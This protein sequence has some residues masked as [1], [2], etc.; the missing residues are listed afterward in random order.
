MDNNEKL[1]DGLLKADGIDPAGVTDSE[2]A[3]FSRM[4][5]AQ[6]K[7][8]QPK[9]GHRPGIWR[10]IMKNRITKLAAAAI[11]I[12]ALVGITLLDKTVTPAYALQQ[13]LEAMKKEIWMHAVQ[14]M[15]RTDD[16]SGESWISL[17]HGIGAN[18]SEDGSA[19]FSISSE[20]KVYKYDPLTETISIT[21]PHKNNLFNRA[22]SFSGYFE[23]IIDELKDNDGAEV[24]T[25][26]EVRNGSNVKVVEVKVPR[27]QPLGSVGTEFWRFT[28][29]EKTFL[30]VRLELEGYNEKAEFIEVADMSFDYPGSGPTDIYQLGVPK[31][32]K[33]ID[34]RPSIEV[35]EI[36]RN[37]KAAR[38][39]KLSRYTALALYTKSKDTGPQVTEE[40]TIYYLDSDK[41]RRETLSPTWDIIESQREGRLDLVPEM[42]DS[43]ESMLNWWTNREHLS[44]RRAYMYDGEHEHRVTHNLNVTEFQ[45]NDEV[46][47][48]WRAKNSRPHDL[49][50]LYTGAGNLL[51]FGPYCPVI[52]L[53][54]ND[55]SKQ[56][57]LICLQG[58]E[59][60]FTGTLQGRKYK[61]LCYIDQNREY[62]CKRIEKYYIQDKL[63]LDEYDN[64]EDFLV[65]NPDP[66]LE[67]TQLTVN[68]I[69]EFG[70]TEDGR[71][72][73]KKIER[74]NT[75]QR[76]N[77][78]LQE[79]ITTWMVYLDTAREFP[80]DIF[81][82]DAFSKFLD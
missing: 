2:R 44:L 61:T 57:D 48:K 52:T 76:E 4:L 38:E 25:T 33:I 73:P 43:L 20:N 31:T 68:E 22:N 59:R 75:T 41:H 24:T 13:S 70:Q 23:A 8:K 54:E 32:A 16:K 80:E 64:A 65:K 66:G 30:P 53:V 12:A 7:S 63:W 81:D 58:V 3:T 51:G 55:Y 27:G 46:N 9:P 5:D 77:G 60:K 69:T 49:N 74:R 6:S 10:I 71:W 50:E 29:E 28:I 34:K 45:N 47:T 35:Q 26:S 18:V 19:E 15:K 14:S 42:G 40:A 56:N 82:S 67:Y 17:I 79:D 11:I 62:V 39:N 78:R 21:L 37:Y 72:Y 36:I 1:F